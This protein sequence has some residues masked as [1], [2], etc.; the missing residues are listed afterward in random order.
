MAKIKHTHKYI[1]V[2]GKHSSI[3]SCAHPDCNHFI[4]HS[5]EMILIGRSSICWSCDNKFPL[6]EDALKEE[7][8]LCFKCRNPEITITEEDINALLKSKGI[9]NG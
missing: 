6:D 9:S 5:Q 2:S 4:W 1:K 3:W 8:P 7:M